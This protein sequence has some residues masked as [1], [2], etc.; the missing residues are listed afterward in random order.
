[1]FGSF[2][3]IREELF[4]KLSQRAYRDVPTKGLYGV[5]CEC[6]RG[7]EYQSGEESTTEG[8]QH[9]LNLARCILTKAR[10]EVKG[11]WKVWLESSLLEVRAG[12]LA[13]AITMCENALNVHVGTGRLWALLISLKHQESARENFVSTSNCSTP[14]KSSLKEV[15]KSGECWCEGA[16]L[17]LNPFHPSFSVEK[18]AAFLQFAKVFT[19]QFGDS[20][21][22]LIRVA[23]LSQLVELVKAKDGGLP[24]RAQVLECLQATDL[25]PL[26]F[27]LLNSDPNYGSLWFRTRFHPHETPKQ[28]F[29]HAQERVWNDLF[30]VGTVDVYIK[31]I[32]RRIELEGRIRSNLEVYSSRM[33]VEEIDRY[34]ERQLR[35]AP[36]IESD[37]V[38]SP[39]DFV[40]GYVPTV[41]EGQRIFQMGRA[42]RKKVLFT[43]DMIIV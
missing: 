28:V 23:Y 9:R 20:F 15:P 11:E 17:Y 39:H 40:C 22:E 10:V 37:V 14:L 30:E 36:G 2:F 24:T 18:A 13:R 12:E 1:M 4:F 6:S 19:P 31:A 33:S 25:E 27:A 32:M 7:E 21:L 5:L 38:L 16:R 34:V 42:Q 8:V 35:K 41:L 26:L 3:G 43:D 29:K